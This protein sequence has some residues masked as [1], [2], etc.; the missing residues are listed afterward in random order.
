LSAGTIAEQN[1]LTAKVLRANPK[2][3]LINSRVDGSPVKLS[4]EGVNA[5]LNRAAVGLCL[6]D[7][8]G[9]NYASVEYM[10]AGLPVVSTPSVGGREVYFDHEF[11]IICD[12]NP[13]AVRDAVQRLKARQIPR[14]YV[15][16]RTLAK[17][18]PE[19]RR[20]L[21][22][23]DDLSER[24]GGT[25]RFDHGVWPFAASP[26]LYRDYRE[27]LQAFADGRDMLGTTQT[28]ILDADIKR[29]LAGTDGIQMEPSELRT[30]VEAIRSRPGCALLVFGCGND[31]P[32]WENV[33][34]G[35]ATAF[36]EDDAVWAAK[37]R[38]Q[39]KDAEI[40]IVD[41]GTKLSDWVSLLNRSDELE[42]TLPE[43]V[44]AKQ[45]DVIVVDGPAGHDNHAQYA[46]REAAGRMKAIYMASKLVAPGGCVFVHDC[47]RLP[48]QTYAARYLGNDRLFVS[49]KGHA[50]LQGYAF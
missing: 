49:V 12:P 14:D 28:S 42:L 2:H 3:V 19:R 30:V 25:R 47:E 7:V 35:G 4:P 26:L 31:S 27:H 45:W 33:N 22:L 48:E 17:F 39:L 46:G 1:A 8:E 34:S 9:A 32:F 36:V 16:A 23:I 18:E 50:V 21:S 13:E 5:A 20:F 44:A 29:L 24:L 43:E 40:H 10:L 15:R 41:Y 6:S 37:I 11:C 38:H